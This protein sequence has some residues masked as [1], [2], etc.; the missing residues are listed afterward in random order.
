MRLIQARAAHTGG[1]GARD[2]KGPGHDYGESIYLLAPGR[3]MVPSFMGSRPV[4]A[5]HGYDPSHPDMA[6]LMWS[7]RPM[8]AD[9]RHLVQVRAHLERELDALSD[10]AVRDPMASRAAGART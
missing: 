7:N 2:G 9:V 10:S 5:M 6:A 4:Q 3:L 8:S 1:L